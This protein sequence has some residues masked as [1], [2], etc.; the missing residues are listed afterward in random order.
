M[1]NTWYYNFGLLNLNRTN[2][3]YLNMHLKKFE[4]KMWTCGEEYNICVI[5]IYM[6]P[7]EF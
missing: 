4:E 2:V 6:T 7:L 3:I 5:K 1:H